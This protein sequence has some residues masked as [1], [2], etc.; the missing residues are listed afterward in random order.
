MSYSPPSQ[1]R[2]FNLIEAAIVLAVVGLVIGGI[3][4]AASAVTDHMKWVNTQKGWTYYVNLAMKNYNSRTAMSGGVDIEPFFLNYPLPEGWSSIGSGAT[5]HPVD[6]YGY[7]LYASI[8]SANQTL[9][10]GYPWQTV[11]NPL[12]KRIPGLFNLI[13]QGYT[14]VWQNISC[15]NILAYFQL[16]VN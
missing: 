1:R 6:P 9:Q 4:V 16:P 14:L 12:C 3:W 5:A 10:M 11:T 7:V 13:G 2:G 8:Q 15:T